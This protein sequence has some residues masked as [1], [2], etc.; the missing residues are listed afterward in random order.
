MGKWGELDLKYKAIIIVAIIIIGFVAYQM[1]YQKS[2]KITA[3]AKSGDSSTSVTARPYIDYKTS[4]GRILRVY[5]DDGSKYWVNPDGSLTPYTAQ[6]WTVPGT[7]TAISQVR[8]GFDLTLTGKYLKDINGDGSQD[9][10]VTVN[11]YVDDNDTD[12]TDHYI[13]F[14]NYVVT[15]QVGT[16]SAGGSSLQT[17]QSSFITI[18]N[19]FSTVWGGSPVQ[20]GLYY[21]KYHVDVTVNATGYWGSALTQTASADYDR[22]QIGDWQWKQAELGVTLG[23]ASS[24]TQSLFNVS[25]GSGEGLLIIM[26]A[27]G[28]IIGVLVFTRED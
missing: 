11:S 8:Y 13:V 18:D 3:E 23:S 4:D 22:T 19:I 10:T 25:I 27:I 14:N 2:G 1:L 15:Y 24:S 5:L 12:T 28:V 21:P 16:P 26:V 20:D 9:I 17:I 6:T 7:L